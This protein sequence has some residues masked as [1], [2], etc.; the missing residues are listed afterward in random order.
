MVS[1]PWSP[2]PSADGR[3]DRADAARAALEAG[4]AADA[5]AR[6]VPGASWAPPCAAGTPAAAEALGLPERGGPA[7]RARARQA[8]ESRAR[9]APTAAHGARAAPPGQP[10]VRA[11]A[12]AAPVWRVP[13]DAEPGGAVE[14]G[15]RPSG[16]SGGWRHRTP[17]CAVGAPAAAAQAHPE[18]L[19][20]RIS[21]S[22][23]LRSRLMSG[24]GA[25]T[26]RSGSENEA[27]GWSRHLVP[28]SPRAR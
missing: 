24:L 3:A 16:A 13:A 4:Q 5:W 14:A 10:A 19:A 21:L 20:W 26:D 7:G 2:R 23:S 25:L 18:I 27:E 15:A 6:A 9:A 11:G 28:R 12:W 17:P 1:P 22:L 8:A